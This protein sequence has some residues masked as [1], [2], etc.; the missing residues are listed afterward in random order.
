[1]I[2]SGL[3]SAAAHPVLVQS[4]KLIMFIAQHYVPDE[5]IVMVITS[6][7]VLDIRLDAIERAFHLPARDSF[8]SIS[9]EGASQWYREH[10][11]EVDELIQKRYLI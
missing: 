1:M 11:E 9:Y 6:E 7:M 8:V 4:S 2:Q 3:V 5:K 10:Q